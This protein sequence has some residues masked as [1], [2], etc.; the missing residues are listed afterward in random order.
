ME[1]VI[2]DILGL[3]ITIRPSKRTQPVSFELRG[4]V[5]IPL[6]INKVTET[7]EVQ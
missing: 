2:E 5:G 3:D 6:I 4:L 1:S 7:I